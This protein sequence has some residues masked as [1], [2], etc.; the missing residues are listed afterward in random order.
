MQSMQPTGGPKM[1]RWYGQAERGAEEYGDGFGEEEE[2]EVSMRS[3][4]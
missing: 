2:E 4:K 1:R 3:L